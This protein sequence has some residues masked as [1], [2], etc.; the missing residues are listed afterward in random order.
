MN[1][2]RRQH[3]K[4]LLH[5]HWRELLLSLL[6]ILPGALYSVGNVNAIIGDV[7]L[8]EDAFYYFTIARSFMA[9]DGFTLDGN[10]LTN[11]F[12]PLQMLL[13]LPGAALCSELGFLRYALLLGLLVH[14]ATTL[15]LHRVAVRLLSKNLALFAAGMWALSL[16]SR[17]Q[18]MNGMETG[19]FALFFCLVFMRYH[20]A[21]SAGAAAGHEDSSR[22]GR[23]LRIGLLLGLCYL[24]RLDAVI[25]GAALGLDYLIRRRT[26]AILP[27][28]IM[29]SGV[30]IVVIPWLLVSWAYCGSLLPDSGPASRLVALEMGDGYFREMFAWPEEVYRGPW[31]KYAWRWTGINLWFFGIMGTAW[32]PPF[33]WLLGFSNLSILS[34]AKA[35][36][37]VDLWLAHPVLMGILLASLVLWMGYKAHR[38]GFGAMFMAATAIWVF[39]AMY[40]APPWY[41]VRYMVS[42]T[43]VLT[44]LS[45]FAVG[46]LLRSKNARYLLP[47]LVTA[48]ALVYLVQFV[49][50]YPRQT[51]PKGYHAEALWM[52]EYL[53][54]RSVVGTF[55]AGIIGYFSK[56]RVVNLDGV[57][58]RQAYK[59]LM[60]K[61]VG[62]YIRKEKITH[63]AD[64]E[65]V[66]DKYLW[67]KSSMVPDQDLSRIH[68][69]WFH[70]WQLLDQ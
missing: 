69:G 3:S 46:A 59:A 35:R 17:A 55:Q 32:S 15:A 8:Q 68:E 10:N 56:H 53:P 63:V 48:L 57:V 39:D 30:L 29:A 42:W 24:A 4:V 67:L 43:L 28:C 58:N 20:D 70:Y 62:E 18:H 40:P 45:A 5:R 6:V 37:L 54:P 47:A 2:H 31:W 50:I 11:G 14:L 13:L 7:G 61:R 9:G 27:L 16:A 38:W 33:S 23:F 64:W 52:N 1:H 34:V 21:L 49:N 19:L 66:M 36:P 41:A 65:I 22:H 44:L 25:V 12:H 60:S 26:R 51:E